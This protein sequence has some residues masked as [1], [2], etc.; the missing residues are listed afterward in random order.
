MVGQGDPSGRDTVIAV[1]TAGFVPGYR[2][3]GPIRSLD[4]VT[5]MTGCGVSFYVMTRD[6]DVGDVD[7]YP[8]IHRNVWVND[9]PRNIYYFDSSRMSDC[10]RAVQ[11]LRRL[12]PDAYYINSIWQPR[13]SL[14]PL[15]LLVAGVLP[16]RPMVIAPRGE[17]AEEA[18]SIKPRRKR[19]VGALLRRTLLPRL[20]VT[21]HATSHEEE[22]DIGHWTPSPGKT[23]LAPN[24]FP[25][26]QPDAS[27]QDNDDDS[28]RP[29]RVLFL[30]RLSPMKN[31]SG[32]IRALERVACR[33]DFRIVGPAED[34]RYVAECDQL[35][36]RLPRHVHVE[37][38]GPVNTA[39]TPEHFQWADLFFLPTRHEN[40]GHVL[41]EALANS[42][43]VLASTTTPWTPVFAA[44]GIPP[45]EWTDT[46]GFASAIDRIG[47]LPAQERKL[48]RDCTR[49]AY[50][51]WLKQY[52]NSEADMIALLR[53]AAGTGAGPV[54]P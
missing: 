11:A 35:I 17:L 44:A 30:S 25:M 5:S 19:V 22:V 2:G 50:Q 53:D 34:K 40:F 42:C 8:G 16:R 45:L 13:F 52:A 1:L 3:G 27:S 26:K 24:L 14:A 38:L 47:G 21:W 54:R 49:S 37:R 9:G 18:L 33:V 31:L 4:A 29:L 41:R 23:S 43:P 7:P 20:D 46:A 36:R 10:V 48:L 12:A 28:N 32:A 15:L 39:G 51:N 6:R